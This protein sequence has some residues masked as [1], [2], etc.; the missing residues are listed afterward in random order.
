MS[1]SIVVLWRVYP[2]YFVSPFVLFHISTII[3]LLKFV[4]TSPAWFIAY[5]VL[6]LFTFLLI[7]KVIIFFIVCRVK[8]E[9]FISLLWFNLPIMNMLVLK[10][11]WFWGD[12]LG[13]KLFLRLFI[14][15]IFFFNVLW[16]LNK[17]NILEIILLRTL[18]RRSIPAWIW[19][20]F[21][22]FL[23]FFRFMFFTLIKGKEF[24]RIFVRYFFPFGLFLQVW[25]V[26]EILSFGFGHI[27]QYIVNSFVKG[28]TSN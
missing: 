7:L 11:I 18:F 26:C 25:L 27:D 20:I 23:K 4:G 9:C 22:V 24:V 5:L 19:W 21:P 2:C 8:L 15:R 13:N 16:C 12:S 3:W 14:R 1:L 28:A 6:I 10:W 17:S